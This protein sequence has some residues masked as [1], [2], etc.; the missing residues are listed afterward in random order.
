MQPF[1]NTRWRL[2]G[3]VSFAHIFVPLTLLGDVSESIFDRGFAR[4]H[5]WIPMAT[6]DDRLCGAI[7]AV[8]AGLLSTQPTNLILD[9]WALILSDILVRRFSSYTE[10]HGRMSFGKIPVP[11]RRP[12]GRLYRSQYRRRSRS[13]LSRGHC[14]NERLSFRPTLQGDGR[15]EPARLCAV[16]AHSAGAGDAPSQRKQSRACGRPPAASPARRISPRP[17]GAISA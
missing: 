11:R 13:G 9:S 16:A 3:M 10:R 14:G 12:C 15:R 5:L 4:E 7:D 1:E 17:F 2:E 8:Q 6:R